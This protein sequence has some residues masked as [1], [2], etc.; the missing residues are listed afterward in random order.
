M[1][2]AVYQVFSLTLLCCP[3]WAR[4]SVSFCLSC[5]S[6]VCELYPLPCVFLKISAMLTV[7]RPPP[8]NVFLPASTSI[9]EQHNK[10]VPWSQ[11]PDAT[12]TTATS[13][14]T[15]LVLRRRRSG[16]QVSRTVRTLPRTRPVLPPR[17]VNPLSLIPLH[18]LRGRWSLPRPAR[19]SAALR[20]RHRQARMP[21]SRRVKAMASLTLLQEPRKQRWPSRSVLLWC[22]PCS[23]DRLL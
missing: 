4:L 6:P 11:I 9:F 23:L 5:L 16:A 14:R 19:T 17:L 15:P 2:A 3:Q 1:R 7:I 22:W 20:P 13:R 10:C 21:L 18:L 8:P 12:S